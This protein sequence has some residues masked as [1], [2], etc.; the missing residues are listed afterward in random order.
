MAGKSSRAC[1]PWRTQIEKSAGGSSGG[2]KKTARQYSGAGTP[3]IAPQS[4]AAA[5]TRLATV[6]DERDFGMRFGS[7]GPV[8]Y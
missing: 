7:G 4:P 5:A 8:P 2:S 1:P 3:Q 6:A